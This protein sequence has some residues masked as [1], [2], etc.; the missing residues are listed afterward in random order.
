M[1]ELQCQN[2]ASLRA[3]QCPFSEKDGT[4][5]A[6][7]GKTYDLSKTDERQALMDEGYHHYHA[8]MAAA[9]KAVDAEMLVA[10]GVFVPR[11]VGKDPEQHAGVWPGKTRDERYPPTLTSLGTG[12][13]D[14]LDV[15]FYRANG[16][17]SV[18]QTFR[19]NLASTGFFTPVVAGIRKKKP[20]IMG[21]F[22][23]FDSVEKTF[24]DAVENM[25]RVRD[26]ALAE[27]LDGML[28]WTYDSFE[29]PRLY[30]ATSDWALFVRKMGS[31]EQVS[32]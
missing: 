2:E 5:T 7:N 19:L 30:H 6:A 16:K 9:I 1:L 20:V 21:E 12:A 28:Y 31:F 10:E 22:G 15:H 8:R 14:F 23:A 25:V 13:L 18:D 29:Q 26:L 32:E 24:E 11:A 27:G 17:E 3:D 4:F